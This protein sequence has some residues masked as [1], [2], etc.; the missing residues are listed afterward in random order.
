MNED[1]KEL[2][3]EIKTEVTNIVTVFMKNVW[4][5]E[6]LAL[7]LKVTASRIRHMAC[8]NIIPYYKQNGSLYFKRTEIEAWLTRHRTASN[9]DINSKAETY[10]AFNRLK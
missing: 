10:C 3:T 7:V 8:D 6:D 9:D 4:D 1:F 2:I 5:V